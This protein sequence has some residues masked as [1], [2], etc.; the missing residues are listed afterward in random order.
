MVPVPV[1]IFFAYSWILPFKKK[2]ES[3]FSSFMSIKRIKPNVVYYYYYYY[4][5]FVSY[6]LK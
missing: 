4:S 6:G 2:K 5:T 3:S 1:C